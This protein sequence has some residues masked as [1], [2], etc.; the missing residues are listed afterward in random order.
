MF[1]GGNLFGRSRLT[2]DGAVDSMIVV[3]GHSTLAENCNSV[4]EEYEKNSASV[5]LTF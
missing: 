4:E 2:A 1:L 5:T 3:C